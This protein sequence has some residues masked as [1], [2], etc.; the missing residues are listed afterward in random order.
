MWAQFQIHEMQHRVCIKNRILSRQ[1]IKTYR[2]RIQSQNIQKH[3]TLVA[4]EMALGL[5]VVIALAKSLGW[6]PSTH[7]T[8]HKPPVIPAPVEPMP[9]SSLH[10]HL[11]VSCACVRTH[12]HNFLTK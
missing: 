12:T 8:A 7:I 11:C 1:K 10:N 3:S 5:R 4:K 2:G 6:N 9:S